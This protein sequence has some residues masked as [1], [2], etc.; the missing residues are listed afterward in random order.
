M[1]TFLAVILEYAI[2]KVYDKVSEIYKN[3]GDNYETR[4]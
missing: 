2:G 4:H 1:I 3:K